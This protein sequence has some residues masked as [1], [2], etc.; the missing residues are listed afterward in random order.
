MQTELIAPEK[1]PLFELC[2]E[3][4]AHWSPLDDVATE[5]LGITSAN[6]NINNNLLSQLE[7]KF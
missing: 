6:G 3:R 2:A 4:P 5:A 1:Q 7:I